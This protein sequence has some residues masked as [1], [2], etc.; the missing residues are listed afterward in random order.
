LLPP[1]AWSRFH[2]Q[3][4][5][6]RVE[7]VVMPESTL[8]GSRL[9][10]LEV[11]ATRGIVISALSMRSP[12]IEGRFEDLQLSIGDVLVLEGD[13]AGIADALEECE[14]LPLASPPAPLAFS[15]SWQPFAIFACGV[16]A[17][18]VLRPDIALAGVVLVL[19]ELPGHYRGKVRDNY[20]LP[21]GR[22]IIIAT[23]RL[24]AFDRILTA[25]PTRA[26][27]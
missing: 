8:V 9:R 22:R 10:S 15:L 12:R 21:D 4:D 11:F 1:A 17:T 16:A 26:R 13:R 20:D 18:S 2:P 23:D 27:C 6:S 14:C 3:V 19:P 5:A 25:F 7:A 24:S